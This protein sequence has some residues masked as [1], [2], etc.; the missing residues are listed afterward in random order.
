MGVDRAGT[1]R[2]AS[3]DAYSNDYRPQDSSRCSIHR[4]AQIALF[5]QKPSQTSHIRK[6]TTSHVHHT[7][8]VFLFPLGTK[9]FCMRN[10][11]TSSVSDPPL[12]SMKS[13]KEPCNND[14]LKSS[15]KK[16]QQ[17]KSCD[18]S[19]ASINPMAETS[20]LKREKCLL[21]IRILLKY[22]ERKDRALHRQVKERIQGY[23]SFTE[24]MQVRL[25]QIVDECYWKRAEVFLDCYLKEKAKSGSN[26]AQRLIEIK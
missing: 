24:V 12:P 20:R 11:S 23:S 17:D 19:R 14:P 26:L 1:T 9:P 8:K 2:F 16:N 10:N 5:L 15:S 7:V 4:E 3:F 21:F 6:R 25:K 18:V 22:L 13:T